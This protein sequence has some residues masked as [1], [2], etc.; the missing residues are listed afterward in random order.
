MMVSHHYLMDIIGYMEAYYDPKRGLSGTYAFYK[1]QNKYTLKQIKDMLARQ[2]A[3]QLNKQRTKTVYFHIV[4]HGKYSYQ[5]DLMFVDEDKGYTCILCII[6]VI[7]RVAYVYPLKRKAAADTFEAFKEWIKD[8]G[9]DNIK[10]LQT[11]QGSEFTNKKVK[12]LFKDIDY[13]QVDVEDHFAQGKIERFN[14]TL[15]R[16]IT[17]YQ[18]AYK[19]RAWVDVLDDLVYNYNHR[20]HRAIG[21]APIEANEVSQYLLELEKY[22]EAERIFATFKVGDRVLHGFWAG[23]EISMKQ[24]SVLRIMGE[25]EIMCKIYGTQKFDEFME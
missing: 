2:E 7:T 24:K 12:E 11:D 15:R 9:I 8:V 19:T 10:H 21:C 23:T 25:Q 14:Q 16:L 20:Y 13:Y 5:A 18:T 4:G 3:Y 1:S 22:P 6:N 17:L